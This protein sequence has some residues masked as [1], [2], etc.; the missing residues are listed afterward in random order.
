MGSDGASV[1]LGKKSGVLALLKEQQPSLIGIHCSAHRLELYYKD[2]MKK[3]PMAEKVL[4]LL[5]GLYYI[6]RNC[7]LNRTNLKNA[8]RC[9]SIKRK[10]PTR[11]GGTRWV[12]HILRALPGW[13]SCFSTPFRT[14]GCFQ[15][16]IRWQGKSNR[17]FETAWSQDIIAM[18]LFLQDILTVLHK[19][20]LKFQKHGSIVAEVSLC[21]NTAIKTLQRFNNT[22]GP[23]LQKLPKFETSSAPSAGATT[24][25]L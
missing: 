12:G 7:P 18:A 24:R 23:F 13:V 10:L 2:A 17:I 19:V 22:D 4:T 3:V 9:L 15:R 6:Y 21:I 11:A 14:T 5:T 8:F 1:T 16:K 20:S 25:D